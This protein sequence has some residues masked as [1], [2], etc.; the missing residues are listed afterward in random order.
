MRPESAPSIGSPVG[1]VRTLVLFVLEEARTGHKA[2]VDSL[3]GCP[4]ISGIRASNSCRAHSPLRPL[5]RLNTYQATSR[6]TAATK[7][8][9]ANRTQV[10]RPI[11]H[12][13]PPPD[14][15]AYRPVPA[16]SH[17]LTAGSR[18]PAHHRPCP[19]RAISPA[20]T[21]NTRMPRPDRSGRGPPRRGAGP[22]GPPSGSAKANSGRADTRPAAPSAVDRARPVPHRPSSDAPW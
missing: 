4:D 14:G 11:S 12:V 15:K 1:R 18:W 7:R 10:G 5:V 22:D 16:C 9:P 2:N 21:S 13:A 20:F 8:V 6:C 17:V 3:D 19:S